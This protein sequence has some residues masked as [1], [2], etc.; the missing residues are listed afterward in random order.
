[1]VLREAVVKNISGVTQ[2]VAKVIIR[3]FHI[4]LAGTL[5]S[6]TFSEMLNVLL[7]MLMTNLKHHINISSLG[8]TCGT[9]R[10]AGSCSLCMLSFGPE[11]CYGPDCGLVGHN[12]STFS[13]VSKGKTI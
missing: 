10:S 2:H 5:L 4:Y 11:S 8:V 3:M 6:P 1:M 13:C 12:E 9:D 7:Y